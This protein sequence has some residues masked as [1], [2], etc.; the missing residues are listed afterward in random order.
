MCYSDHFSF[1]QEEILTIHIMSTTTNNALDAQTFFTPISLPVSRCFGRKPAQTFLQNREV[2]LQKVEEAKASGQ[3]VNVIGLKSCIDRDFLLSLIEDGTFKGVSTIEELTEDVLLARLEQTNVKDTC[4]ASAENLAMQVQ[5][6]LKRD[7]KEPDPTDRVT[8]L[9]MHYRTFLRNRKMSG[10]IKDKPKKA[11]T[12][13]VSVLKPLDFKCVIA[14][15]ISLVNEDL[16]KDLSKFCAH[17]KERARNLECLLVGQKEMQSNMQVLEEYGKLQLAKEAQ[18]TQN[19][20][21]TENLTTLGAEEAHGALGPH[22]SPRKQ[23]QR[24]KATR[25]KPHS[26]GKGIRG[27]RMAKT[28]NLSRKSFQIV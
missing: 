15:D 27:M 14:K 25:P 22:I 16:K 24:Q 5:K 23:A 11:I 1:L 26:L 3:T 10:I 13:I 6:H 8:N 2:H 20:T 4:L 12:H 7:L 28:R 21:K 19:L 18:R 17:L 9:I